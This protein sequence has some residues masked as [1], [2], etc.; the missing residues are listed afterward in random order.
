MSNDCEPTAQD[1]Q[2]EAV[3][4][5]LTP[6]AESGN[7]EAVKALMVSLSVRYEEDVVIKGLQQLMNQFPFLLE[8]AIEEMP[9]DAQNEI[10]SK[11]TDTMADI[12]EEHGLRL[13]DHFRVTDGGMALTCQAIS[14]ISLTGF[15]SVERL[16]K[17]NENL[18]YCGL[19]RTG[20]FVHPLTEGIENTE[21]TNEGYVNTW[22]FVSLTIAVAMGWAEGDQELTLGVLRAII[23][24]SAPTLDLSLAMRRARYDDR[25]LLKL[26]SYANE[27]LTVELDRQK[28]L[29]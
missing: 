10:Q 24:R 21:N 23:S 22:G 6:F 12:L 11:A 16:G 29:E 26:C 19:D 13:E 27:G 15:P 1:L 25:A 7:F 18:V 14:A 20:G 2:V 17:G 28:G 8:K 9:V 5:H 3:V 4:K